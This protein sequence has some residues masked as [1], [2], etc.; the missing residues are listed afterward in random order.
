MK[1]KLVYTKG[2]W[3]IG[4]WA[5]CLQNTTLNSKERWYVHLALDYVMWINRR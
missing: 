1:P 2:Y 3:S 4:N 5:E